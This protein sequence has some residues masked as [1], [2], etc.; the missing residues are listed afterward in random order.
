L[1]TGFNELICELLDHFFPLIKRVGNPRYGLILDRVRQNKDIPDDLTIFTVFEWPKIP[2]YSRDD[3]ILI[4]I[5]W[6]KQPSE[7]LCSEKNTSRRVQ[8]L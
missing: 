7:L 2:E 1:F 4:R 5:I 3:L 6:N 8:Y